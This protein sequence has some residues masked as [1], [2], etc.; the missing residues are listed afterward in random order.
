[1]P[2]VA[3]PL[4][5]KD[6]AEIG[7]GAAWL[8]GIAAA[9]RVVD[10]LVGRSPLVDAVLGAVVVDLAVTRAGVR[11]DRGEL[12]VRPRLAAL[13]RGAAVALATFAAVLAACA[14]T[15]LA[16][17]ALGHPSAAIALAL[18]R[19]A[20]LAVRD[21]LLYRGLVLTIA[22]RARV[23]DRFAIPFAAVAGAAPIVLVPGA[24]AAAVALAL[25][26]GLAFA[27]LWR[28]GRGAW[29][30]IGAHAAWVLFAGA[31]VRG[32]LLD[33][34]WSRGLLTEGALAKGAPALVA[35]LGW[36]ATAWVLA[37]RR[38]ARP[39]RPDRRDAAAPDAE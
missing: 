37:R 2:V 32:Y 10:L 4:R 34:Q 38:R 16:H 11:W 21:E 36:A 7:V 12:A 30:P 33:V 9:V 15:G 5:K 14:A 1:M 31:L 3:R 27:V 39:A 25:T 22:S 19:A 20:G 24:T 26:S 29:A 17:V 18:A 28:R 23:P 13:A 35:A 8:V 6:L